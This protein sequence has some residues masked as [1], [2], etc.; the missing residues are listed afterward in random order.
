MLKVLLSMED[1]APPEVNM[2]DAL[3]L[4]SVKRWGRGR[5]LWLSGG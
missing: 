3:S 4:A 2:S 1:F 5:D